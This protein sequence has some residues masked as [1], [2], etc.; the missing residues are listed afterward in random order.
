MNAIERIRLVAIAVVHVARKAWSA[1]APSEP[2]D[3]T[4]MSDAFPCA[5]EIADTPEQQLAVWWHIGTA[6]RVDEG[7]YGPD[8]ADPS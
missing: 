6:G 5:F 8:D 7:H 1:T 4:V 2:A 3:V